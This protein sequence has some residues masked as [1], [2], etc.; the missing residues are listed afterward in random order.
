M[1]FIKKVPLAQAYPRQT[2]SPTG[3]VKVGVGG[4]G[5]L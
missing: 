1:W 4:K 3:R 2:A 5:G